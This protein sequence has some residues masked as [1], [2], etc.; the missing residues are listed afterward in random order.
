MGRDFSLLNN[1]RDPE[2]GK[3]MVQKVVLLAQE[4]TR[5][6]GRQPVL[7]EVCGTHTMAI[8]RSGLKSLLAGYLELRSGPGCPVCVTDQEDIDRM[9]ALAQVP[10]T[11]IA[12]F[13]D[14]MRAPGTNSSLER[15]RARG[16]RVEVFYSPVE[17]IAFAAANPGKEVIF[18]GVGFET[19]IPAVAL[20]LVAA[21]K[22]GLKNY[23]VFSV[24][25]LV[26]PVMRALLNDPELRFDGFILPG[27]VSAITGRRAFDFIASEYGIPAVVA[28]FEPVDIIG[29]VYLLMKQ[30][31]DSRAE[32]ANGYRRLVPEDGNRKAR[33]LIMEY[34]RPAEASWRGFGMVAESG[35]AF[36]AEHGFYDAAARF[37]VTVPVSSSPAGCACGDVLKGKISPSRCRL[38]AGECTPV[39]P[40]G[41][42]MVSSE[43]VCAAC[44]QYEKRN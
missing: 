3:R 27:H 31:L 7:M 40:V 8:A 22:Q 34:F 33:E 29:A 28:G 14:M 30:L 4:A 35:L 9:I 32:T 20:S 11:V 2:L 37:P 6:L 5:R 44:Y 25:K 19:T 16:T 43:G 41:P 23:S 15:E 21:N 17:A 1:F 13:G 18:L 39:S 26:P 12:T 24:H 36:R 38:F 42:C 10:G